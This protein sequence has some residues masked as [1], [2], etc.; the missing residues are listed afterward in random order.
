MRKKYLFLL[1]D[2]L[3]S[4]AQNCFNHQVTTKENVTNIL[5]L[6]ASKLEDTKGVDNA[7]ESLNPLIK[8]HSTLG[9]LLCRL[10]M[11]FVLMLS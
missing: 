8:N 6:S 10:R 5:R 11:G 1:D 2:I 4:G 3:A 7:V 9:L